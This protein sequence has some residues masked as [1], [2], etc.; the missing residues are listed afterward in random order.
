MLF[1]QQSGLNKLSNE[2]NGPFAKGQ[3]LISLYHLEPNLGKLL[4]KN[5]IQ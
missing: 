2:K 1:L 4:T 3:S 5:K